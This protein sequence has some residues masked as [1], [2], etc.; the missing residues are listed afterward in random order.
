[1]NSQLESLLGDIKQLH[2]N[3]KSAENLITEIKNALNVNGSFVTALE[4]IKD[5][6]NENNRL[7]EQLAKKE[8]SCRITGCIV[9][10]AETTNLTL[11]PAFKSADLVLTEDGRVLKNR[12]GGYTGK[13]IEQK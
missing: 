12:W 10:P 13:I 4:A 6:K 8:V 7:R 3:W 1:M 5:L 2:S 11:V 9:V